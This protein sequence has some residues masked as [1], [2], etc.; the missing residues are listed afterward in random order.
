MISRPNVPVICPSRSPII[1]STASLHRVPWGGFPDFRST[2]SGL[3]LLAPRPAALRCLR[4]A[5]PPVAPL[6]SPG[7]GNS[8]GL[9]YLLPRRPRRLL[10]VE[11]T[12]SPRFLDNPCLHAPLSDP[13]GP[14]TPGQLRVSDAAFR[15]LNDVGSASISLSRLH[16]AAYRHPVYASQPGSPPDHATLGS[17]GW[18]TFAGSGLAPAGSHRRFL[19]WLS[20]YMTSPFTRLCLAQ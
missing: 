12:R 10:R 6:R 11:K 2:I 18:P 14:L 19:S 16:H 5:V 9:D 15:E 7:R 20:V 13:G 17:G 1:R 4:L 8:Q 3:R